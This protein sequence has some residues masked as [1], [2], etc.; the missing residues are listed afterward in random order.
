MDTP[1]EPRESG[2]RPA[3][4]LDLGGLPFD[5]ADVNADWIKI[6]ARRRLGM[7]DHATV[8]D[9]AAAEAASRTKENEDA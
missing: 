3:E 5:V 6:A 4:I 2:K 9:M 1:N 8:A 7:P